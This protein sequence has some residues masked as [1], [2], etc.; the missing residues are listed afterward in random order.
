L[1][2]A[3]GDDE[4]GNKKGKDTAK[5]RGTGAPRDED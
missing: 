5:K 1:G 4:N 2:T 3:N